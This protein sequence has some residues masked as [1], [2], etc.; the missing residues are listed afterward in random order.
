MRLRPLRRPREIAGD[1][2]A[3]LEQRSLDAVEGKA[4]PLVGGGESLR[5]EPLARLV[6]HVSLSSVQLRNRY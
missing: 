1:K 6:L 4:G 5:E 3:D 2:R